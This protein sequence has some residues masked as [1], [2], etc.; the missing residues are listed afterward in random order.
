MLGI[1]ASAE[2]SPTSNLQ[3]KTAMTSTYDVFRYGLIQF[4]V[5]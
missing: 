5:S 1:A 3:Q 4:G 2:K